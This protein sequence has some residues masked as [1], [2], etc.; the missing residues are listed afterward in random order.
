[1]SRTVTR[2]VYNR[3]PQ[4]SGEIRRRASAVVRKTVQ[5]IRAEVV[6]SMQGPKSGREYARSGKF[7]QASAPGQAPAIDYG[8]LVNSIKTEMVSD[9]TGIVFTNVEYA[10]PLE[11]GSARMAARPFMG[12]A[13]ETQRRP[14]MLGMEAAIRGLR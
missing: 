5:V 8:V 4:L 12:P 14:F 9:V 3:L 6:E 10:L 2:L 7:H 1:M 13:A 11:F